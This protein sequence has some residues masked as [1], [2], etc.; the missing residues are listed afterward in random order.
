MVLCWFALFHRHKSGG[1]S[2]FYN[3]DVHD[4]T[5]SK[6]WL[7]S[8]ICCCLNKLYSG[9]LPLLLLE[10]TEIHRKNHQSVVGRRSLILA[11][12]IRKTKF[13][14]P[15]LPSIYHQWKRSW[16]K[17]RINFGKIQM[18]TWENGPT[19]YIKNQVGGVTDPPLL[20][21]SL[22]SWST[23]IAE[24]EHQGEKIVL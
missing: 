15:K 22:I 8:L 3:P 5:V 4:G 21:H 13:G 20:P 10:H 2:V 7:R 16:Q 23:F 9:V 11:F 12:L 24:Q 1:K 17:L 6:V 14:E 18:N 19:D